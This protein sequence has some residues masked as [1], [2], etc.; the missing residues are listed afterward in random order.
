MTIVIPV[1]NEA[2]S[3]P[4]LADEIKAVAVQQGWA[5]E[6]ILIDDGST[7][8]TWE[9]VSRLSHQDAR[10][11]GI[12]F[13]RNFGKA[14]AL[15]AGFGRARGDIVV[16]IDGDL[17]DDPAEVPKL[18]ALLGQGYGTVSGWKRQRHDPWHKVWPSRVFNGM[19]GWLTGVRLHDVNCGLKAYRREAVEEVS[20]YGELHRFIP[21]LAHAKGFRPGE[22]EVNHR[23]RQHG[24]SKF[25][26]KRFL[27]GLLDLLTVKFLTGYGTRPLHLFGGL[28]MLSFGVGMAGVTYLAIL[29]LM[30]RG[31]IGERPL[32]SYS[33][34]AVLLGAQFIA[35]GFLAE[36]LTA[37]HIHRDPP[38]SIREV[39]PKRAPDTDVR[40]RV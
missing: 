32:L 7:D 8:D 25:G 33:V 29:W 3:L 30:G 17:Q 15:A 6:V 34:M 14:A 23:P 2:E 12:R 26:A 16:T 40:P 11:S 19:V 13:R 36:L 27:R 24:R 10:F 4:Q 37:Y 28:G 38:Y 9:V 31:P 1:L 22:V 39:A 21:V 5:L 20:L 18:I 35:I